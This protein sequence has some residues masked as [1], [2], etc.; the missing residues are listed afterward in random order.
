MVVEKEQTIERNGQ[1]DV[2]GYPKLSRF[3][4]SFPNTAIV[5]RFADLNMRNILYLQA[6]LVRLEMELDIIAK[7]DFASIDPS[8]N[9]FHESWWTLRS[10]IPTDRQD[11]QWRKF[12]EIRDKLDQYSMLQRLHL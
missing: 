12:L 7:R 9:G 6:E 3:M 2:G 8:R 10:A 11:R 1:D 4:A 5:R